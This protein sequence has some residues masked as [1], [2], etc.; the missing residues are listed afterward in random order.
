M[1][2]VSKDWGGKTYDDLMKGV[3]AALVKYPWLDSTRMAAAG[4]SYGGYM[5]AWIVGHDHRVK[6]AV[7]QRGVY[8]LA[9]GKVELV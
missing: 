3:D 1:D 4:G 5:T 2:A 9:T 6:A 7:A 8:D